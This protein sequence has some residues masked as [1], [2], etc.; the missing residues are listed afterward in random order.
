MSL[1]GYLHSI[2]GQWSWKSEDA[3]FE[4]SL[5][6]P[7][8]FDQL[9]IVGW[10]VRGGVWVLKTTCRD[11]SRRISRIKNAFDME[12]RCCAIEQLGG[13]FYANPKDYPHL[14]LA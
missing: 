7:Q 14:D 5:K 10:P 3:L 8:P 9:F 12:K 6:D 4:G 13:V 11:A 1:L 2:L